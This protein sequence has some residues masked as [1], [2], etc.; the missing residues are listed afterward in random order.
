M[1]FNFAPIDACINSIGN[2]ITVITGLTNLAGNRQVAE[3]HVRLGDAHG[4]LA[5][6]KTEI[7]ALVD[8]NNALEAE[9]A[10]LH[11]F[12]ID[13]DHYQLQDKGNGTY[14]YTLKA[15]MT[16][17]EPAHDVCPRCFSRSVISILQFQ[18]YFSRTKVVFCPECKTEFNYPTDLPSS[19][20][21]I[22][23]KRSRWR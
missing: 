9:V 13:K 14:V 12:A 18:R 1:E 19:L 6:A 15:A 22:M 7:T 23:T 17:I 20:P 21:I 5:T 11:Q 2:A 3:L 10:R 8:R 16:A 4:L